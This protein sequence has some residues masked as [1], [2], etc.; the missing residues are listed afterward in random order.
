MLNSEIINDVFLAKINKRIQEI[1]HAKF[2]KKV[3][4]FIQ[5]PKENQSKDQFYEIVKIY[6]LRVVRSDSDYMLFMLQN[7]IK[8]VDEAIK[9]LKKINIDKESFVSFLTNESTSPYL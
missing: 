4:S 5:Q 8:S 6:C 7:G 2:A 9:D 1:K 3:S